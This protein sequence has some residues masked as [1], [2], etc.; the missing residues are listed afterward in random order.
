MASVLD[1]G[2]RRLLGYSTAAAVGTV[3]PPSYASLRLP[4]GARRTTR[5]RKRM[6]GRLLPPDRG[7][8]SP[9]R[10]PLVQTCLPSRRLGP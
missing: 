3:Q 1:L 4:S 10:Y 9:Q 8:G 6:P 5:D 2:S 7:S